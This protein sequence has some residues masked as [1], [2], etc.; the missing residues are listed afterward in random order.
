MLINYNI[1]NTRIAKTPPCINE[2]LEDRVNS[3]KIKK[4]D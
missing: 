4:T 2:K 1:N 3:E